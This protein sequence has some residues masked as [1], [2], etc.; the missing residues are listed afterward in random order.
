MNLKDFSIHNI[1]D[2]PDHV[3]QE[4]RNLALSMTYALLPLVLKS[5]PNV[6]L[7][8]LNFVHAVMLHRLVVN[9]PEELDNAARCAALAL[10]KNVEFA[11]EEN[12]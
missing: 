11:R 8:A 3:V 7:S 12:E 5:D 1:K 9:D 2:V 10:V 6:S 4:I